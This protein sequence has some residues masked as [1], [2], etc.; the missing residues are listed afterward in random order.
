MSPDTMTPATMPPSWTDSPSIPPAEGGGLSLLNLLRLAQAY[1]GDAEALVDTAGADADTPV[2][3]AAAL[4]AVAFRCTP[5]TIAEAAGAVAL[6]GRLVGDIEA[7]ALTERAVA[8][9]SRLALRLLGH[10]AAVLQRD[11]GEDLSWLRLG[12]LLP[13]AVLPAWHP[14][15]GPVE[16]NCM[17]VDTRAGDAAG[18]SSDDELIRLCGAF[19]SARGAFNRD[20]GLSEARSKR[21][22]AVLTDLESRIAATPPT[23]MRG[24]R[25]LAG[26][27]AELAR[28]G[29]GGAASWDGAYTAAFPRWTIEALLRLVPADPRLPS[30]DSGE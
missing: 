22:G 28:D 15:A 9:N 27:A 17:R 6:V 20:D 10:I 29:A 7:N 11:A 1:D 12:R 18:P 13:P 30:S 8:E 23:T 19:L 14:E 24:V 21:L 2:E 4:D 25:A 3:T 26:V 16:G 5:Q